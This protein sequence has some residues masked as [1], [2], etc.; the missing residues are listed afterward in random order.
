MKGIVFNLLEEV[1][2][3]D[4]GEMAWE[5]VLDSAGAGGAYTS[6]G[7]YSDEEFMRLVGAASEALGK[8]EEEVVRWFG[9]EAIPLFV[10]RYPAFFESHE[11]TEPFLLT[12]NRI[13]HP[14]VRKL[15][16]GAD[17]PSFEFGESNGSLT[18]SYVSARRLCFFGEGLIEG[19]AGHYGER[20][21]ISQPR[22]VLRG[23]PNCE[24]KIRLTAD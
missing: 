2:V 20:A 18:M 9:R 7:S 1:V 23:D 22:C 4:H 12:L 6:L 13:I 14:E 16:P 5:A 19:A 8:P 10:E 17:V 3:R 15:Y 11:S 24:F 21:E